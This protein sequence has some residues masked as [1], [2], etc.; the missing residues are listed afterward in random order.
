MSTFSALFNDNA[1]APLLVQIRHG[2]LLGLVVLLL[3]NTVSLSG[4]VSHFTV[5][6]Q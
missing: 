3:I 6:I 2:V 4:L 1:H 5:H